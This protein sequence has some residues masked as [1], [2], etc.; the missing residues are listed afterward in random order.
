MVQAVANSS[1]YR[2]GAGTA[3][4]RVA[5]LQ[6]LGRKINASDPEAVHDT[7]AML[8]SQLFF[9]PMLA[10]MRK[11][12]FGKEFGHGGRMEDAFGEQLDMH[13]ADIVARGDQSLTAQVA[14]K[15]TRKNE[16]TVS[17]TTQRAA[18]AA[19]EP[20]PLIRGEA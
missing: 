14:A 3:G 4:N 18:V 17:K 2:S 11:L 9:A 12:P 10:E 19:Y 8:T 13:M 16:H 7:A 1:N 6:A 20:R 15:L 5:T